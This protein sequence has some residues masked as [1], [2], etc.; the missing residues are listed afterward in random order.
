MG[1]ATVSRDGR[2]IIVKVP[3]SIRRPAGQKVI[4]A[5]AGHEKWAPRPRIDNTMVK[6]LVLPNGHR[7]TVTGQCAL[8]TTSLETDPMSRRD[9]AL[10][11]PDPTM[12]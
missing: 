7:T 1:H 4:I 3:I 5:P 10:F 8:F 12:T 9:A 6:A 2:T 11:P